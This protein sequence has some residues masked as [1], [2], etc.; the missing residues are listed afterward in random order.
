M[1]G[2]GTYD[3]A[4]RSYAVCLLELADACYG[5]RNILI[6]NDPFDDK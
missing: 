2:L 4:E 1:S 3:F 5:I 6:S